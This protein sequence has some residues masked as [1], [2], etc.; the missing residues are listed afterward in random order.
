VTACQRYEDWLEAFHDGE[1]SG[2][3]RWRL[4]RHVARCPDCGAEVEG[5]TTLAGLVR[6][7]ELGA[8]ATPDLW[9]AIAARLPEIDA[10]LARRAAP[11]VAVRPARLRGSW[12]GLLGPLPIGVGGL[13]VAAIALVLLFGGGDL[14]VPPLDDVV[15]ELDAMGRSVA[16]LASDDKSTIIWVLD[17]DSVASAEVSGG[18]AL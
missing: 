18:A 2:L 1:L 5:L 15:E 4:A 3:A 11:A 7:Q 8:T 17:P 6:E 12:A 13:A 10:D 16:V 9:A 14:P